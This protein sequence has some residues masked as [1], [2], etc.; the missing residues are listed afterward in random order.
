[1][2]CK[3]LFYKFA[4]LDEINN[5]F[6]GSVENYMKKQIQ[7]YNYIEE[8]VKQRMLNLKF[9]DEILITQIREKGIG[10]DGKVFKKYFK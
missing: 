1:M 6:A 7:E 3:K 8:E 5:V 2:F 10:K 4:R 9:I